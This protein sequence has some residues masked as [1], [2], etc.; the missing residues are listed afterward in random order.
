MAEL[1][2]IDFS[3]VYRY[4]TD[5]RTNAAQELACSSGVCSIDDIPG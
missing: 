4:E 2:E 3:K 1:P 5:D